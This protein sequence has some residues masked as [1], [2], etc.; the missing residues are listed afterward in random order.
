MNQSIVA[1]PKSGQNNLDDI[2][3]KCIFFKRL[4]KGLGGQFFLKEA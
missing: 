2:L 3:P 4:E 1:F